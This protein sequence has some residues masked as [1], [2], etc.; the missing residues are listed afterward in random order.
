MWW[1]SSFFW[2]RTHWGWALGSGGLWPAWN[3]VRLWASSPFCLLRISDLYVVL[4]RNL[5]GNGY[6]H[7]YIDH[8]QGTI[9]NTIKNILP[10]LHFVICSDILS[11]LWPHKLGLW[12]QSLKVAAEIPAIMV[13]N[14]RLKK[15]VFFSMY[16]FLLNSFM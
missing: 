6:S 10:S 9:K 5:C 2:D 15:T 13:E 7:L 4:N 14:V 3:R 1:F 11:K 12:Y 8:L 16:V